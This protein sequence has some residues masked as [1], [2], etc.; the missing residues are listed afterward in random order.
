[1]IRP[2]SQSSS[3]YARTVAFATL[4]VVVSLGSLISPANL[5]S[6]NELELFA[7]GKRSWIRTNF[8]DSRANCRHI[9]F[10]GDS[11]TASSFWPEVFD[12]SMGNNTCS[13]N[14]A[15]T[16]HDVIKATFILR[17]AVNAGN[18]PDVIFF[19]P[20]Y[21][22]PPFFLYGSEAEYF[23]VYP[24]RPWLSY[25]FEHTLGD[26]SPSR[27]LSGIRNLSRRS[28]RGEMLQAMKFRK[29][30]YWWFDQNTS[31]P[32]K[33][34]DN[35]D[36]PE[37]YRPIEWSP[38]YLEAVKDFI[39]ETRRLGAEIYIVEP[40]LRRGHAKPRNCLPV[41]YLLL[42]DE[43]KDLKI[44]GQTA[45]SF[46]LEPMYFGDRGH[47]NIEGARIYSEQLRKRFESPILEKFY[48]C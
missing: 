6:Q 5:L 32:P 16:S 13:Y 3:S 38:A 31:L 30:I 11:Q 12:R 48:P 39:R 7:Y 1:M 27:V 17:D 43:F 26:A 42:R 10:F 37:S 19:N 36:H 21:P 18:T 41:E 8:S 9:F 24:D 28:E 23:Y 22:R 14:L 25:F 2:L 34:H 45:D 15:I 46:V 40:P 47:V 33:F 20:S 35:D 44:I 4:I 29:G